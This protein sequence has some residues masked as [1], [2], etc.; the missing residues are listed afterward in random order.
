M[1]LADGIK[2]AGTTE[3]A[4]L[5]KALEATK[6]ASP[7]GETIT[8]KPSNIIKHQGI[9]RQ[10]ILQWQNGFQEVLWPFEAATAAPVFPF[11]AWK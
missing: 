8:F 9:T 10:K 1:I 3:T 5:V 2:A 6:Y 4:A 11:P 7:L